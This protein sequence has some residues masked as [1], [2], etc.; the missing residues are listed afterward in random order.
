MLD[1]PKSQKREGNYRSS[2]TKCHD[3]F[4]TRYENQVN[5]TFVNRFRD[6]FEIICS[7]LRNIVT[8]NGKKKGIYIN[9]RVITSMSTK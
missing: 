2:M 6:K 9:Y 4:A 5:H 1:P 7:L 8:T 3:A